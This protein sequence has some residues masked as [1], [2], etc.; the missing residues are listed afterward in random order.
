MRN[1]IFVVVGIAIIA[2][3]IGMFVFVYGGES[4]SNASPSVANENSQAA[5]VVPFTEIVHGDQSIVSTRT[6][7]IVTSVNEL[8]KLWSLIEAK[9]KMP[10]IDFSKHSVIAVFAGQKMTAGYAISVSEVKDEQDRMITVTLSSPDNTCV[11]AQSITA[12][13][14]IIQLPATSLQLAHEDKTATISCSD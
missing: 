12:P 6:N 4:F 9:E 2:I 3:G 5:A 1:N 13:Y 10:V 7:Y 8:E 11:L 14:Q